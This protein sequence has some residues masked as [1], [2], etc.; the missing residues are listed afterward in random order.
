[1]NNSEERHDSCEC[2][3]RKP[4]G[5]HVGAEKRGRRNELARSGNLNCRDVYAGDAKVLSEFLR[6]WNTTTAAQI[7]DG[8]ARMQQGCQG[9]QPGEIA[10]LSAYRVAAVGTG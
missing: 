9:L 2:V 8:V 5:S 6:H 4:E 3:R 7:K 1:M 10:T